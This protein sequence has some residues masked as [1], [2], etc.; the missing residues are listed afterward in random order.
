MLWEENSVRACCHTGKTTGDAM[1]IDWTIATTRL[2]LTPFRPAHEDALFAMNSDPQVMR[3]LGPEQSR[4]DVRASI[5]R[6]KERWAKHGF[7]WWSVFLKDTDT[8]IGAACLQHLAHDE[9]NPLEIGWR[10]MPQFHGKGYATEAGQAAMDFGFGA[11]GQDYICAVADVPNEASQNVMKRLGMRYV[12]VRE[13]YDQDCAYFE[14]CK[15]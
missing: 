11:A 5:A 1:K 12:G 6:Q 4:D 7:G 14:T 8:Q 9:A 15:T 10:L 2:I 13:Y 3:Y